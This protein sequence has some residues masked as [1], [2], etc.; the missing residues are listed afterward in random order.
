M[1]SM[2][3]WLSSACT[4]NR[5]LYVLKMCLACTCTDDCA[6]YLLTMVSPMVSLK[7]FKIA[8][9]CWQ[10]LA[11]AFLPW[12]P[13]QREFRFE[14]P[15]ALVLHGELLLQ[16]ADLLQLTEVRLPQLQH[17][18]LSEKVARDVDLND[19]WAIGKANDHCT[20]CIL[21]DVFYG[22]NSGKTLI[23]SYFVEL[24]CHSQV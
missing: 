5:M 14:L 7:T 9:S 6:W 10:S 17:T 13:E 3:W 11:S 21:N 24:M 19:G 8:S 16:A 4:D 2:Y 12:P 15:N 22:N 18:T 1:P 20:S 23:L